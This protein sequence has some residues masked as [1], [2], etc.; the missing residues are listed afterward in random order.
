M[1]VDTID[2]LI[3]HLQHL[4]AQQGNIQVRVLSSFHVWKPDIT[5]KRVSEAGS[6]DTHPW[7]VVLNDN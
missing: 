2:E 7:I 3:A 6:E 1:E 4:R 5:L